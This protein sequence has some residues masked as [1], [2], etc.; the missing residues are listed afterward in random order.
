MPLLMV[1][2]ECVRSA[3]PPSV[4]ST[5]ALIALQRH[6]GRLARGHVGR[7]GDEVGLVGGHLVGKVR[8]EIARDRGL[9][10]GAL[11]IGG[12][13]RLPGEALVARPLP[14]RWP[15]AENIDRDLE[16]RG[17]PA[18]RFPRGLHFGGAERRAVGGLGALLVGGAEPDDGAAGDQGRP[19]AGPALP[20]AP[21]RSPQD[22]GRRPRASS[23]PRPRSGRA[24][25]WPSRAPSSRRW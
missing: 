12:E 5:A 8:R 15:R 22:R 23:S 17:G 19:V 21:P 13:L 4:M 16:R 20:R 11:R 24:G 14:R 1:R 7:L 18:E 6:L 9:E 2:F 3:E 25:P 10:Q